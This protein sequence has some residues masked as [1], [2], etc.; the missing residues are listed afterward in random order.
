MD[1]L[2]SLTSLRVIRQN[3]KKILLRKKRS[4]LLLEIMIALTF[5]VISAPWIIQSSIQYLKAQSQEIIQSE[6][7]RVA[8]LSFMQIQEEFYNHK[9]HW[10]N[11]QKKKENAIEWALDDFE[12]FS[13]SIHTNIERK[14]LI[15][16]LSEKIGRN[17]E[18]FRKIQVKLILKPKNQTS[19]TYD[20]VFFAQKIVNHA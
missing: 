14:A 7:E 3:P 2:L 17:D 11:L 4:F 12:I 6:L 1:F 8:D 19:S 9:I 13:D 5:I 20:S 16:V 18:I 15:W 10:D